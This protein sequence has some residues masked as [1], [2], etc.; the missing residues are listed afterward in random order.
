MK[1]SM[2]DRRLLVNAVLLLSILTIAGPSWGQE[3][4]HDGATRSSRSR[5]LDDSE[6]RAEK[7][8]ER[9]VSLPAEKIIELLQQEPGLFLQV[10]RMLVRKAYEQGRVLDRND[11][12][13]G[14][15]FRLIRQ[16]ED[17]R[18]LITQEIVDRAYIR[19]RPSRE[20]MRR[21]EEQRA[22]AAEGDKQAEGSGWQ[23]SNSREQNPGAGQ[24]PPQS[25]PQYSSPSLPAPRNPP[26][27]QPTE[28]DPRRRLIEAEASQP[29]AAQ[30]A[31]VGNLSSVDAGQ[32]AQLLNA[33]P[34]KAAA[35]ISA[36]S[37]GRG[38]DPSDINAMLSQF[39]SGRSSPESPTPNSSPGRDVPLT[40]TRHLTPPPVNTAPM[41]AGSSPGDPTL[42]RRANPYSDVPSL[43]D[44]YSQYSR[45]SPVLNRF[46]IDVFENGSGNSEQLPMDLPVGPDYV[47]GTGDG[48]N[49]DLWGS[50][51]QKLRET[52]DREGRITLPDVGAIQV[53]GR[54][55]GEVQHVV[56]T[57]LRT[58]FRE[59]DADVSLSQLRSIR[60]Y[61]VGDVQRPGAY[62]VS[63]LSTPLNA[64][65]QAGGPTSRGSMRIV[66]QYRGKQ[67]IEDVDL[68][69]LLLHGVQAG[70]QHLQSGDTI[71]VPP[72]GSEVTVQGMVRRPAIYELHGEKNLAEVLELAGG[73]LPS[74]TLRH[75][76]V[77]RVEAHQSRTML[78]LDIPENNNQEAVTK[79]LEDFQV[80]D[81]D[82]IKIL[83]I[84]PVTEK[85]VYLDGHVFRPGKYAYREGMKVTDLV[86]SY[87]NLLPEPYGRHAEIIR[88]K[89]PNNEPE[90]LAFNLD[91]LLQG[92]T[93]DLLL[94]P[95]DT[96]RIFGRFD[97]EEPPVVTV[98][99][100]VREPGDHVTNGATYLRDAIYLAGNTTPDAELNDA[101]VFRR[102]EDGNL[103]VVSVN[104]RRALAGD[105]REN[106]LLQ[107][108]D[109]V[110]VHKNGSRA[111]P[112]TVA[113][114]GEVARPGTYPLGNSM[115]ASDL[116]RLAGGLKRSAYAQE[117]DLARYEIEQ[118]SRVASEHHNIPID[119]ALAGEPDTDVRLRDGDV[120]TVRQIAGWND[121][122]ATV[123]VQGEVVHPG[124]FGIEQGERLSDVLARAGGF[125]NAAYPYG[126]I[127]L[128]EQVR[129]LEE[130]HRAELINDVQQQGV[131]LRTAPEAMG[132]WSTTLHNL[133]ATSATG[134]LVVHIS[135][136]VKR[137]AHTPAD[138]QVRAGDVL[139]IPKHPNLVLVDGAVYN[140]IAISFKPGRSASWY[141]H[142]AGGPTTAADK[143]N[144]FIIR[145]DGSVAGGRNGLF[146]GGALDS[147]L[148]PGDMVMVPEKPL[149]GGIK[150]R[151]ML[152]VAQLMAS[153]G[154]PLAVARGW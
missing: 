125:S 142:Q 151:Q 117:A 66:K 7:E 108:T 96:V 78:R 126:A 51:S 26:T 97:F 32:I 53:A 90:V 54:S 13:D 19:V 124:T 152:Q 113:I 3:D 72:I 57:A 131:T 43:Y 67:L 123:S 44:L 75:V 79:A 94:K 2:Y 80:Q 114:Q 30:S 91:D 112:P 27:S 119:K 106:I 55:L 70:A 48:L 76:D 89:A 40:E 127:L 83:P 105:E 20:E 99:G 24:R 69:D 109:R 82:K 145:A 4:D 61:V 129:E 110:F 153:V 104:L 115:M 14:V 98:T 22:S 50:S 139:F 63:S 133:Q 107:P 143:K 39:G 111:D 93:Q 103:K 130:K 150:W 46:G 102:M 122:G 52:V 56:Q 87:S 5:A 137:W 10:K 42:Q 132:Q 95:F 41:S 148:Q 64:L 62:D 45:R 118:G 101:Q 138:I 120:L 144:I 121:I 15:L 37:S 60:I 25:A 33:N 84:L 17:T 35:L 147:I 16:D 49:I 12:R 116:V 59:L 88:L 29:G 141:L 68:Y 9:L 6:S 128:R 77:E 135:A 21:E 8:A 36:A 81:S 34:G 140:A 18:I 154:A 1:K 134:R 47:V 146:A 58:Q 74:G 86:K 28:N 31:D 92:K 85:S 149:G 23:A 100:E 136:D 71:L 11:L 38:V 65:Y 73:V